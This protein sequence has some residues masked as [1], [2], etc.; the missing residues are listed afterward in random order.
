MSYDLYIVAYDRGKDWRD[1]RT[2]PYHWSFF[3]ETE[4][5]SLTVGIAHQ[6]RGMPGGFY[7]KGAERADLREPEQPIKTTVQIGQIP[8]SEVDEVEPLLKTVPIDLDETTSWNCQNWA[9]SALALMEKRGWIT[10]GNTFAALK[11][12]LKEE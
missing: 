10:E 12:W 7:Y 5:F 3:I 9:G 8:K 6:L 2:K 11:E 4:T 1:G